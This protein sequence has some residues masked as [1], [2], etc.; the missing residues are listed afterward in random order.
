METD[1]LF[2]V[3]QFANLVGNGGFLGGILVLLALRVGASGG[4]GVGWGGESDVWFVFVWWLYS[5]VFV[6]IL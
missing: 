4:W 3:E 1:E 6:W 5:V 2:Y